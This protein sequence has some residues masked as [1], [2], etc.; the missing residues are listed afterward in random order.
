[1]KLFSFA[2]GLAILATE[3]YALFENLEPLDESSWEDKVMNSDDAWMITFYADWCPYCKPFAEE[4]SQAQ[5]ADELKD[6]RVRFGAV[7]VMANRSLTSKYGIKRSPSI[8]VFGG[9]KQNPKDYLGHRKAADMATYLS[10]YAI[11]N[12]FVVEKELEVQDSQPTEML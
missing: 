11:N 1:M 6:K 3:A 5:I 10:Q 7:D 4:I 12:G 9:D 8:K 2:A